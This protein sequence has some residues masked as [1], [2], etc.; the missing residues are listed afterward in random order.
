MFGY[1][2]SSMVQHCSALGGHCQACMACPAHGTGVHGVGSN[3]LSL[4]GVSCTLQT[5]QMLRQTTVMLLPQVALPHYREHWFLARAA[6][7]YRR[8]LHLHRLHGSTTLIPPPDIDLCWRA[9]QVAAHRSSRCIKKRRLV[10]LILEPGIAHSYSSSG[11]LAVSLRCSP[12]LQP[13]SLCHSA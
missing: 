2:A 3:I 10:A 8:F 7:R 13:E 1:D 12:A 5:L 6:Q 9:H 11:V 4:R